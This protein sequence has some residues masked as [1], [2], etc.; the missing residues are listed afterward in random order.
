M[1]L[2]AIWP[3]RS[4]ARLPAT[5]P[6]SSRRSSRPP[7]TAAPPV[8]SR[9][10]S[11]TAMFTG[12]MPAAARAPGRARALLSSVLSRPVPPR[13]SSAMTAREA[14]APVAWAMLVLE[15]ATAPIMPT[16]SATG[17]TTPAAAARPSSRRTGCGHPRCVPA[18]RTARAGLVRAARR[19][20]TS[21]LSTQTGRVTAHARAASQGVDQALDPAGSSP[22]AASART[23]RA[24]SAAPGRYPSSP[25]A[26]PSSDC[27]A[28]TA[29]RTWP[30]VAPTAR[31]R[32]KRRRRRSTDSAV[33]AASTNR[34]VSTRIGI[35]AA[36]RAWP[37]AR[38]VA[39]PGSATPPRAAPVAIVYPAPP[40]RASR[41]RRA[42]VAGVTRDWP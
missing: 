3:G 35:T 19:A 2:T 13:T 11:V 23:A 25:P 30:R 7:E 41:T 12:L 16:A 10:G 1:A 38:S 15:K 21:P 17:T 34:S 37:L 32:A 9:S 39:N 28:S 42:R 22:C 14:W 27:S 24:P 8:N 4:P 20:A 26:S 18:S 36:P 5:T 29:R 31:S 40:C 33:V 6:R